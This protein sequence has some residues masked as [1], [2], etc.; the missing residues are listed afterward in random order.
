MT[1]FNSGARFTDI[2]TSHDSSDARAGSGV[3]TVDALFTNTS[4][5]TLTGVAFEVVI[6][7]GNNVLL[8]ADNGPGGRGSIV[9]VPDEVLGNGVLDPGESFRQEFEIGVFSTQPFSFFV[10]VLGV[11]P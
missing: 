8:N 10:N 7:T 2:N 9:T 1:E 11:V 6:L 5:Q 3:Y 4:G